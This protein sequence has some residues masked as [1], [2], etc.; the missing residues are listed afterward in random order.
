MIFASQC[1]EIHMRI[2][3]AVTLIALGLV[4]SG[5]AACTPPAAE[6]EPTPSS[7]QTA[8][9]TAAP[10]VE[11]SP[12]E[13][14]LALPADERPPLLTGQDPREPLAREMQDSVWDYVD[15]SWS[16]EIVRE[17]NGDVDQPDPPIADPF[18]TLFL[19]APDGDYLRL[20][21]LR[22]DIPVFVEHFSSTERLG[23]LT[24]L[25]Y[26]EER[27]TV[28]FDLVTGK[29]SET[30]AAS[31]FAADDVTH[32]DGWF[33]GYEATLPDGR[34]VWSGFGYGAPITGVFFR[35]PGAGITPS[36]VGSA[37]RAAQLVG[38]DYEGY[39][40]MGIDVEDAI[41][42]YSAVYYAWETESFTSSFVVHDLGSDTWTQ[43]DRVGLL[44]TACHE[45]F[46]VTTD[47]WVGAGDSVDQQGL[48]RVYFDGRPDE[49]VD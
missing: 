24:R 5:L 6:P 4:V 9:P 39:T 1:E 40:C 7:A 35:K 11:L 8:T 28:Q 29:A 44:P 18:Q 23:F 36:E 34:E 45:E 21:D 43:A 30:W 19:V 33:V 46:D 49:P 38:Y 31:G 2:H 37:L 16:L 47:Y 26:A 14:W 41:A 32:R 42:V 13:A 12:G 27:Q 22:T 17:I 3:R 15:D 10:T 25:F 20:F 48:F